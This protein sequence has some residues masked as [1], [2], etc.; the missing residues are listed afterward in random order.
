MHANLRSIAHAANA[1]PRK[2]LLERVGAATDYE[3]FHNLVLVVTYIKPSKMMK[4]A[5]G[6]LV[7]FHFTDKT[8]AE[9]RFQGKVGLVVKM[10]PT[11]F[12]DD[13]ITKFGGVIVEPGDW[14]MY[15]PSDGIELFIR[16]AT[17]TESDG[18]PCRL[19]EDTAIKGRIAS[20]NLIY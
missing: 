7:E 10:G 19:I 16:D 4:G 11:A 6:E 12:K 2:V 20:P 3:V 5:K 15:R 18:L 9:D 1:D 13:S 8:L 14:V 17:G